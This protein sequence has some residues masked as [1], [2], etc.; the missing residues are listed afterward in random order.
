MGA[1]S[2]KLTGE[3]RSSKF[4][5]LPILANA[6]G[7]PSPG[8]DRPRA[9]FDAV[10]I[11][12]VTKFL[13]LPANSGGKQRSSAV[14]RGLAQQGEVTICAFDD[15]SADRS[16]FDDLGV[17]VHGVPRPGPIDVLI[18]LAR[19]RSISAGRF[20]SRA[21]ARE[22]QA[23]IT[24]DEP[25]CLVVSYGQLAPHGSVLS[26]DHRILDLHNVESAL[27]ESYAAGATGLRS[28]TSRLEARAMRRIEMRALAAFDTVA[29]V[30]DQ[31]E[32]RLP[33]RRPDR[34]HPEVIVCPNG[35]EPSPPMPMGD[36]PVVAF[37]GLMGWAPNAD[38]AAW[39]V[40]EVW[41]HVRAA[42][43]GAQLL[44]VGRDPTAAVRGLA[45]DDVTVTGTVPEIEPYLARARVAVAP[46]RAG[47]GSR[48][49]ILEA[50]NA[51]RPVVATTVGAEGL[52]QF[53]GHGLLI[54]DDPETYA[55]ILVE[56]LGDREGAEALGQRGNAAVEASFSWDA[57]LA[58]LMRAVRRGRPTP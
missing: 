26:A 32:R 30:S 11:L 47:G 3:D 7:I 52:E 35:W 12:M 16:A 34:P 21:L 54:A 2:R 19:T 46:L 15:G 57:T 24:E 42:A 22:L 36:E 25:D 18:G 14:L 6:I 50:L 38:A 8:L 58:P 27:F 51:G 29:V 56:L 43:P 40:E 48:L 49:K 28:L 44:L 45:N 4:D 1:W 9:S 41:P 31:D 5:I 20:W 33:S 53:N 10:K 55:G 37:V 13:P 17:R 23:I 39:L